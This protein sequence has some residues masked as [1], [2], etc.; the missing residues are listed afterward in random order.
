MRYDG[1]CFWLLDQTLL[2]HTVRWN[3]CEDVATLV[4]MIQ[5]LQV[6][7]A[8]LIGLSAVV[9]LAL[10]AE[11]GKALTSLRESAEVLRASRPTAVNLRNNLETLLAN[12]AV[13]GEAPTADCLIARA[14]HLI[15]EDKALCAR[16]SEHGCALLPEGAR[17][18]THCNTG[19]LATAGSGTA[20]GLILA[21]HRCGRLK[22]VWVDETRPLLQGARLTAWELGEAKVPYTLI[23]DS[24]AAWVMQCG[25]VDAVVVGAD[26]IAVNGDFANKVGTYGLAICARYHNIPFY[27]VAPYTT[28]DLSC[29]NGAAIPIE[30][31][32]AGEVRGVM[33]REGAYV[34]APESAPVYNPAFDVTPANL[35]TRWVLDSGHFDQS[36]LRNCIKLEMN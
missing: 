35:V 27:V 11:R 12:D 3:V 24:M 17:V 33:G 4:G 9:L 20:L 5:R 14:E 22:K 31:R 26:R 15:A 21:A 25:E 8:P 16:L 36:E 32:D 30:E 1:Q 28:I 6:R 13:T 2:P 23:S 7:G 29:P 19:G 34:W 10:L 18:L